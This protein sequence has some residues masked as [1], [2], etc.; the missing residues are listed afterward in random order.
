MMKEKILDIINST[1][2][3]QLGHALKKNSEVAEF[4]MAETID[5]N[6]MS[7][8]QRAYAFLND[9]SPICDRS[10]KEKRWVNFDEGWKFCGMTG[11]CECA[12][13][14]VS[15]N[16]SK[17]KQ[18]YDVIT[19]AQIQTKRENTNLIRYNVVNT[20]Q[21]EKSKLL[22]KEFYND[23]ENVEKAVEKHRSTNM[24]RYGVDNCQKRPEIREK[25]IA[26]TFERYGKL[27]FIETEKSRLLNNIIKE[28]RRLA[29]EY[30]NQGFRDVLAYMAN[31][32]NTTLDITRDLYFGTNIKFEYP[33]KCLRCGYT[34]PGR[35]H[36]GSM[37]E[38][39]QCVPRIVNYTSLEE[40]QVFDFVKQLGIKSYQ[41]N[42]TLIKPYEIDIYCPDQK[43]A[44]EY[45]GLYW[46]S[47]KAGKKKPNYHLEKLNRCERRNL[48]LVTIFSDEWNNQ[49]HKVENFLTTMFQK[50]T[51]RLYARQC[52]IVTLDS[53]QAADFFNKYHMIGGKVADSVTYGLLFDNEIVAAMSFKR[54][55]TGTFNRHIGYDDVWNLTRF[56]T[57]HFIIPGAASKLLNCFEKNNKVDLL[58]T[59]A[60]RRYSVG[61]LYY[62]LG[63]THDGYDDPGYFYV[64]PGHVHKF[65]YSYFNKENIQNKFDVELVN[66]NVWDTM[67][68]LG[69]D[70]ISDCGRIRFKK[71][72]TET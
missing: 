69:W 1:S 68:A 27:Y 44:I 41:T 5:I 48:R 12:R 42:K 55:G 61:N 54:L 10:G 31:K 11:K 63:F 57:N 17:T 9:V 53:Y 20:G 51:N 29:G 16:V 45:G 46:H 36:Y 6:N 67:Q 60:D 65:H 39:E 34:W 2:P 72:Y 47:E 23:P 52:S 37:R 62:E 70:R 19:R 30:L 21:L 25:T 24:D 38:C 58:L 22:H 13:E 7:L 64:S 35:L 56:A 33:F 71:I 59:Y 8:V 3:K 32:Y 49:K 40:T 26:T 66:D 15:A 50:N 18:N 14:S 43:I 4:L 28:Q